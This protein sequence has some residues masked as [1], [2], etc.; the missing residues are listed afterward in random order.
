M[1]RCTRR[2]G[3]PHRLDRQCNTGHWSWAL[4]GDLRFAP[5]SLRKPSLHLDGVTG[6]A[7]FVRTRS[8]S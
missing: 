3:L 5:L 4:D 2:A 8:R 1:I 6:K 7:R